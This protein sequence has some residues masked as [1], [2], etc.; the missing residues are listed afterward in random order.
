MDLPGR[1]IRPASL[2]EFVGQPHLLAP[3]KPLRR[4]LEGRSLRSML[5]WG[6]LGSGKT[7][8]ARWAAKTCD[9]EFVELSAVM[10]VVK[11]VRALVEQS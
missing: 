11:Y 9:A 6:P 10:A 3:G 1:R 7:T 5:L 2:D 4:M 8:L